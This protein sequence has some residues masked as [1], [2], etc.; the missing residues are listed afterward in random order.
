M[1]FG[2]KNTTKHSILGE[3]VSQRIKVNDNTKTYTWYGEIVINN[4]SEE[5][6]LILEGDNLKPYS[7]QIN[8]LSHIVENWNTKYL[9]LIEEKIISQKISQGPKFSNWKKDFFIGAI[10]PID[11]KKAEFEITLEP[12]NENIVQFIGIT[13]KNNVVVDV[14][15]L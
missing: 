10:T 5:T 11:D 13:I 15:I 3:F 9:P 14:E 8:S 2:K 1:L 6:C 12:L 4:Y 7:N